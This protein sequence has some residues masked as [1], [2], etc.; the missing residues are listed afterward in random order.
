MPI[1]LYE[2]VYPPLGF[3]ERGEGNIENRSQCL[4]Q[5]LRREE[6]K[7]WLPDNSDQFRKINAGIIAATD[8]DKLQSQGDVK[9]FSLARLRPCAISSCEA[10]KAVP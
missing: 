2:L 8:I 1:L 5:L 6:R 4:H 7:Q 3:C 9:S 10:S